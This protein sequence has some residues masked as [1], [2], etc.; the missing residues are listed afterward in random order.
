MK[1]ADL[2]IKLGKY[3]L[4]IKDCEKLNEIMK[5]RGNEIKGY[6]YLGKFNFKTAFSLLS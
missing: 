1:R 2:Y 5:K 3:D 4:A 6:A